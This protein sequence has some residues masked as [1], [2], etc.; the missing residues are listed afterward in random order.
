MARRSGRRRTGSPS[1]LDAVQEATAAYTGAARA[2]GERAADAAETGLRGG[3]FRLTIEVA[4][5]QAIFGP[6]PA[7]PVTIEGDTALPPAQRAPVDGPRFPPDE[8]REQPYW[9]IAAAPAQQVV[10][11]AA[12]PPW[13]HPL[14]G[15]GDRLPDAIAQIRRWVEADPADRPRLVL[16]ELAAPGAEPAAYVAGFEL[17]RGTAPDL[18]DLADAFLDLPDRPG[19]ATRGLLERVYLAT[20]PLKPA[21]R[22]RLAARLLLA[23]KREGEPEALLGF[24]TWLD[25]NADAVAAQRPALEAELARI[26]GMSFGGA[27]GPAWQRRVEQQL[28][29]L[30]GKLTPP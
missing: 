18:V 20:A 23:L 4:P 28:A 27:N 15:P 29:S 6:L 26:D 10:V 16:G 19:A 3:G 13:V 9:D 12:D 21:E 30:R 14:R 22:E 24:L 7:G 17:L 8:L 1:L 2:A 5:Q 25:A 11:V